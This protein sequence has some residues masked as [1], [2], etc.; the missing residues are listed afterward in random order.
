MTIAK[1]VEDL[2]AAIAELPGDAQEELVQSLVEMRAER[3]G[4]YECDEDERAA[5]A[6]SA[7]DER[8]G[9]CASDAEI[10]ETFAR[11]GA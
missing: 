2:I 10:E 1:K 11:Y 3:L 9:R 6:R 5:L 8:L 7:E 4:I